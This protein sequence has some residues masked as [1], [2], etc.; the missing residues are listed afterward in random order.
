M[1]MNHR[2]ADWL[3]AAT[4]MG[5]ALLASGCGLF[6][7]TGKRTRL[8]EPTQPTASAAVAPAPAAPVPDPSTPWIAWPDVRMDRAPVVNVFGE[9]EGFA[10][11]RRPVSSDASF[12]QHTSSDEGFDAD[13][14]VD[15][16]AKWLAF[17]ST[18]HSERADIY[19]QRVD[20]TSVT[21]LTTDPAD[22]MQ[23]GFSPDGTQIAFASTRSGNWDIYVMDLDGKSVQQITN[24]PG[25]EMHPSFSPD[26]TRLVY[27]SLSPRS[28]QW[29]LWTV[30]LSTQA[31]KMIGH[32][33]FPV[34]SP[35]KDL[36]RIAF[37]RSRQRGSRWFSLW[38]VDLTDGEPR[39]LTEVTVSSSFAVLT[40]AWSP[41]GMHLAFTGISRPD[42]P[43]DVEKMRTNG[44]QDVWL[45][46]A[47]GGGRQ[48]LTDGTGANLSPFWAADNRI[49]FISDRGGQENIWSVKAERGSTI[50]AV[51]RDASAPAAVGSTDGS[52]I[53]R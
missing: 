15:P 32:G 28:E 24:T 22:D 8:A 9:I 25:H 11:H 31:R 41:D 1:L 14:V 45:V 35:R 13:V 18:R 27:C 44:R 12:Q 46:S 4:A 5:M 47:D 36:D 30:D 16:S 33:L 29:E 26:G 39:R 53:E 38:T 23:P 19:L 17:H 50:T 20:G 52:E 3:G 34:W 43:E 7:T 10:P 2:M 48:K 40:P 37:Q 42:S 6:S 49:Y 51:K 21:Q